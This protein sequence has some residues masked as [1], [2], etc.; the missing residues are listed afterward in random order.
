MTRA[1]APKRG[2]FSVV[3][4]LLLVLAVTAQLVTGFAMM[5]HF[6]GA[7]LTAHIV[8]GIAAIVL[9]LAEWS[10]LAATRAGRHRLAGF[11]SV[12]GG[13]AEWSEAAFLVF[14]SVTV[15]FGALL[16]AMM[17]LGLRLPFATFLDT[18]RAFAIIVAVLYLAH[19]ALSMQRSRRRR[20][21]QHT[22]A[23]E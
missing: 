6:N 2:L 4:L 12:R 20:R 13:P 19:T 7:L 9:T 10:W 22:Q 3:V 5:T 16:A 15:V 23:Q 8:G 11:V 14:A 1:D 18:H 17:Y 21:S